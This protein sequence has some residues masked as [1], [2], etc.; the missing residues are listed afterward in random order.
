MFQMLQRTFTAMQHAKGA[1]KQD[2]HGD[3]CMGV[4]HL[5]KNSGFVTYGAN[6]RIKAAYSSNQNHC[7]LT[8]KA[9]MNTKNTTSTARVPKKC[10]RCSR[11]I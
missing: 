6:G 2:W 10:S 8:W 11:N 4:A 7:R 3:M 5:K 1:P 9:I